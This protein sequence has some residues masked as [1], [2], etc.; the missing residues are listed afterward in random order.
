MIIAKIAIKK[1]KKNNVIKHIF[2][3]FLT[4]ELIERISMIYQN[5]V[6]KQKTVEHIRMNDRKTIKLR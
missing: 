5:I 1:G 2:L 3:L 4:M 6:F